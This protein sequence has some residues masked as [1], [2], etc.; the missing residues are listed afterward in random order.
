MQIVINNYRKTIHS[1]WNDKLKEVIRE[2]LNYLAQDTK[3]DVYN[4]GGIKHDHTSG[5]D[6]RLIIF[7]NA[8]Y[9]K[10]EGSK[11]DLGQEIVMFGKRSGVSEILPTQGENIIVSDEG[12]PIAEY[13]AK[14][15][16][17]NVL[18]D[19]FKE[20][21]FREDGCHIFAKIMEQV[22]EHFK[23]RAMR[24][25]WVLSADKNELAKKIKEQ[26]VNA[27]RR[28]M[29]QNRINLTNVEN[30]IEASKI[31]ITSSVRERN[32]L[33][34]I[35]DG[36][37]EIINERVKTMLKD[38]DL[39]A[40]MPKIIDLHVKGETIEVYT[41][42]LVCHTNN[43]KMYKLGGFRI[44]I[45]INNSEVRFFGLDKEFCRQGYWTSKDPHP[46]VDGS[47]GNACLGNVSGTVAELCAQYQIYPLVNILIDFLEAVNVEDTAGQRV[48]SWD[49][50]DESGKITVPAYYGDEGEE[51][52]GEEREVF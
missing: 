12:L 48:T 33:L 28:E 45:N 42:Q 44:E 19:L 41:T 20:N 11:M 16:Q 36:G 8:T 9:S 24:T 25:S 14:A 3:V 7:V 5:S 34:K 35:I 26:T 29:E 18:F 4:M 39:V 40:N 21:Q 32:R 38:L 22:N 37:E 13:D 30:K 51:D 17:V 31:Q 2:K 47:G 1:S 15:N 50:C 43:S 10:Y 23:S 6:E 46:H 27:A 49:R 52:E